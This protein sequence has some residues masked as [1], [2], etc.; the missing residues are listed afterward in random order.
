MGKKVEYFHSAG[1]QIGMLR[2]KA[3]EPVVELNPETAKENRISE[4][5][6]VWIETIYF[7]E[8]ERVR[9]RAKL[10]EGFHPRL[11]A[12]DHGWWF[13]ERP[14]PEHGCFESNIN[15]VIPADVY[16]PMFGC[17]NLRSI[18]CRIFR[19]KRG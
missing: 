3:P 9:F 15:R 6:W 1:R 19:E 10:I 14:D 16:D 11:V 4:G 2:E 5:D 12:V 18:P 17:S 7:G 13:P 8:K